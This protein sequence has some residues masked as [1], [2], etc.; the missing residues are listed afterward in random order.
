MSLSQVTQMGAA[1]HRREL[2]RQRNAVKRLTA[3]LADG[4]LLT[5]ELLVAW[6]QRTFPLEACRALGARLAQKEASGAADPAWEHGHGHG[7]EHEPGHA[8]RWMPGGDDEQSYYGYV[9]QQWVAFV[10]VAGD[11]RGREVWV[12]LCFPGDPPSRAT[13][14]TSFGDDLKTGEPLA[15]PEPQTFAS[16]DEAM[17]WAAAEVATLLRELG[18]AA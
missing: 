16:R 13:T 14:A 7:P 3:H 9:A 18:N 6:L 10:S 5:P 11:E 1:Q 17:A 8:I 4:R 15:M 2:D 12:A